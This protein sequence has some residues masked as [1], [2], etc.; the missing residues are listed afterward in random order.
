V[1]EP[2]PKGE[3]VRVIYE[4]GLQVLRVADGWLV[5]SSERLE[6][7]GSPDQF[8]AAMDL[9]HII[10]DTQF[11]VP[12]FQPRRMFDPAGRP[13]SR[14]R[15]LKGY[16]EDSKRRIYKYM[17]EHHLYCAVAHLGYLA[18]AYAG[19]TVLRNENRWKLPEHVRESSRTQ[20]FDS[21]LRHGEA[22]FTSLCSAL[23]A[24]RFLVWR[25]NHRPP[26]SLIE[27]V[28]L[29]LTVGDPDMRLLVG[30]LEALW[31]EEGPTLVQYRDCSA[32][33]HPVT[34]H[35]GRC[36]AVLNHA[37]LWEMHMDLPD[38]PGQHDPALFTFDEQIDLLEYCWTTTCRV[39]RC[40]EE[41]IPRIYE[42]AVA[43]M[44]PKKWFWLSDI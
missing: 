28:D 11:N 5:P 34:S 36:G 14:A 26:L 23:D 24:S 8:A 33:H 41:T 3:F 2:F 18:E 38:N 12:F 4:R 20:L 10:C 13:V 35:G 32:A 7:V 42:L 6:R 31:Y 17:V 39:V 9:Q 25:E 30:P 15:Y 44:E 27:T 22:V 16:V 43:G 1:A 40:F 19:L 29:V 37:D 21:A